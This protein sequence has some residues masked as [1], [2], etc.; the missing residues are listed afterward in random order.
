MT[1]SR[2]A[3]VAIAFAGSLALA[4]TTAAQEPSLP[5]QGIEVDVGAQPPAFST[6]YF[7][8]AST[9]E[10]RVVRALH[11]L[12]VPDLRR[13]QLH[14]VSDTWSNR[15]SV[16]MVL[17][18]SS[19]TRWAVIEGVLE[20]VARIGPALDVE[21]ECSAQSQACTGLD[22][23]IALHDRGR[24]DLAR[25]PGRDPSDDLLFS[26]A[27]ILDRLTRR[28]LARYERGD[29]ELARR[30]AADIRGRA[31]AFEHLSGVALYID[32]ASLQIIE[33]AS[34]TPTDPLCPLRGEDVNA[35]IS[36]LENAR[37]FWLRDAT[38]MRALIDIGPSAV[39][40][41]TICVE[42]DER[43]TRSVWRLWRRM[44][45]QN[46]HEDEFIRPVHA[47]CAQAL[48]SI[49][50]AD[51]RA[52]YEG[53]RAITSEE[54]A[55][56]A[57]FV[58]EHFRTQDIADGWMSVLRDPASAPRDVADAV[59]VLT[60][61]SVCEVR[62]PMHRPEH[63]AELARLLIERS[64]AA[65]EASD[66]ETVCAFSEA[67]LRLPSPP[68][69]ALAPLALACLADEDCPCIDA[70]PA[71]LGTTLPEVRAVHEMRRAVDETRRAA[72]DDRAFRRIRGHLVQRRFDVAD[73]EHLC[74]LA[75]RRSDA[76]RLLTTA[77]RDHVARGSVLFE[78]GERG[79]VD[80]SGGEP[81][82]LALRQL[83]V[84]VL[85]G[86]A[87]APRVQPRVI[88]LCEIEIEPEPVCPA[89]G[90]SRTTVSP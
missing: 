86:E 10:E 88:Q 81:R 5:L 59:R 18:A 54:R 19:H 22:V 25:W 46:F 38:A 32:I 15:I 47:A 23:S 84:R 42:N 70:F 62:P 77:L 61:A 72:H 27:P 16:A 83:V 58:R 87:I 13:A 44:R 9:P 36:A 20:P 4:S 82:G 33:A 29:D 34:M 66:F 45:F 74:D 48:R 43:F 14:Y 60:R 24:G 63:R 69:D 64:N 85:S 67:A 53:E 89:P 90:A 41:L 51:N 50:D 2:V 1:R 35:W 52:E 3:Q 7:D 78:L 39:P 31:A 75:T 71:T 6:V 76:R 79:F 55:R 37:G 73:A 80:L 28:M 49:L 65:R 17:P 40:A 8:D 56:L 57:A 30:D 68:T 26:V 21:A 12:G 11:E